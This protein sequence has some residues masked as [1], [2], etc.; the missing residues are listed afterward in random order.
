MRLLFLLACG[1]VAADEKP[2]RWPPAPTDKVVKIRGVYPH[3]AVYNPYG[4]CGIGAVVP[5][6]D[7]LWLITYPPHFP[8]GSDDGLY[9]IDKDLKMEMRPESIGGTHANRM[10]HEESNQLIIGG[11]FIDAQGGVRATDP[12]ILRAR[13]TATTR[14]L[15]DPAHKV[16]FAGMERE[17]YEVDVRTLATTKIYGEMQGPFPGYHGKGA[18]VAQG[19]LI[20][21]NNGEKNWDINKDPGF[22]GPAGCLAESD[23]KDWQQPF[24]VVERTNFCEVTGPGGIKGFAPGDDRVWATGWDKRSVLLELRDQG[25]WHTFR[26]PKA[27]YSHDA[28]HGWFTEWPRIR[29]VTDGRWLMHMHGLFYEFPKTFAA[30]STGGLRPISTHLKMP[31]DYCAWNGELVMGCDDA[32]VM[33]NPLAGQSHS[34]LRFL[35]WSDLAGYGAPA[36]AGG[37]WLA[38]RVKAGA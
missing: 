17:L 14:H 31:V 13:L 7:H 1:A 19:R 33:Q 24:T 29:E 36:G 32:S 11:Y 21:A 35:N 8:Q 16:F 23:G 20:V 37:I 38:D 4:E 22:N 5:W 3:L 10:I 25:E 2:M 34:N 27:S 12:K 6:A 9:R 28:L 26:L 18:I 30:K 15:V